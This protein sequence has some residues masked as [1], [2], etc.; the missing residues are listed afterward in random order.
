MSTGCSANYNYVAGGSALLQELWTELT[1][2]S[3]HDYLQNTPRSFTLCRLS[4]AWSESASPL[5]VL[6]DSAKGG[7]SH[8]Q[9]FCNATATWYPSSADAT[10]W[11]LRRNKCLMTTWHV[12]L[13]FHVK[14][15]AASSHRIVNPASMLAQ[16]SEKH[17][18]DTHSCS[19]S[20]TFVQQLHSIC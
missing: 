2:L 20:I 4:K 12:Q 10:S 7:V 1:V 5:L 14:T 8:T 3:Q 15:T 19:S 17:T 16:V 9:L 6:E 11:S 18:D 13:C